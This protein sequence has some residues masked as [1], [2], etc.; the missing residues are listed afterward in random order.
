L[1]AQSLRRWRA[2]R[3][4]PDEAEGA[5]DSE[6]KKKPGAWPGLEKGSS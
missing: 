5:N 4:N 1:A 2:R 6:A 3:G